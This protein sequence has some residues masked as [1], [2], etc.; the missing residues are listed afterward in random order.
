MATTTMFLTTTA[1]VIT[2][3]GTSGCMISCPTPFSYGFGAI[4][5]TAWHTAD[6]ADIVE[7]ITYSG[8]YGLMWV[9]QLGLPSEIIVSVA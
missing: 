5:P 3:S 4:A 6:H 7:N 1:Q 8:I 9:K 2:G